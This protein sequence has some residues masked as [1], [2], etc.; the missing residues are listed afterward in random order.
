MPSA[1]TF[2]IQQADSLNYMDLTATRVLTVTE[3]RTFG[4]FRVNTTGGAVQLTLPAAG[5]GLQG[6]W[7]FMNIGTSN[8][9]VICADGGFG[10]SSA[11]GD[12]TMTLTRGDLGVVVCD[13][14][15][16]SAN[17]VVA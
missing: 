12:D 4:A 7:Y 6:I 10:G 13:G 11:V 15:D 17:P 2:R 8:L 3:L 14:V 9:T 16:F 5:T 1:N